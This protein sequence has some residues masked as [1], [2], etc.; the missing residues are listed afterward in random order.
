MLMEEKCRCHSVSGVWLLGVSRTF[1]QL[2]MCIDVFA[3]AAL[4]V[5]F[6]I[7]KIEPPAAL[8]NSGK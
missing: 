2:I 7:M 8:I 5:G 4:G 3:A 6:V 1:G